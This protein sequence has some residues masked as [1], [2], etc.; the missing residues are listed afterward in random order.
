MDLYFKPEPY[1]LMAWGVRTLDAVATQSVHFMY[2]PRLKPKALDATEWVVS[3]PRPMDS[4]LAGGM[5]ALLSLLAVDTLAL[6]GRPPGMAGRRRR[7]QRLQRRWLH[8]VGLLLNVCPRQ[9]SWL[10]RRLAPACFL[11]VLSYRLVDIVLASLINTELVLLDLGDVTDSLQVLALG[12]R[13]PRLM[14]GEKYLAEFVDGDRESVFGR[15]WNRPDRST[16][17]KDARSIVSLVGAF[18][19]VFAIADIIYL[20][21]HRPRMLRTGS[22]Q[23]QE[24][25]FFGNANF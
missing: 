9:L 2:M 13:A 4:L 17:S 22:F 6:P 7:W 1:G 23:L 18:Q 14:D 12:W 21:V 8:A 16:F 3:L 11:F 19:Q 10:S 24:L 25:R 20:Y 15:I 5:L